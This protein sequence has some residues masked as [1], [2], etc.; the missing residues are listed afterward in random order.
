M[1]ILPTS[2]HIAIL[3][4]GLGAGGA[5]QVIAQ[6][7]RHWCEAGHQVDVIAFDRPADP[8]FHAFPKTRRCTGWAVRAA[9][10]AWRGGWRRCGASLRRGGRRCWCPS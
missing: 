8:I 5:E 4:S 1:A 2:T 3:T 9:L 10:P 7:A 6:L